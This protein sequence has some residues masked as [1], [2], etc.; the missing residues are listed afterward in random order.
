VWDLGDE[1]STWRLTLVD[2]EIRHGYGGAMNGLRIFWQLVA[3]ESWAGHWQGSRVSLA[4]RSG[5]GIVYAVSGLGYGTLKPFL[6][7]VEARPVL[8]RIRQE[9]REVC[10]S[11]WA[12]H[13]NHYIRLHDSLV[14][15]LSNHDYAAAC[16]ARAPCPWSTAGTGIRGF[17][18]P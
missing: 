13:C 7:E 18:P 14:T 12:D 16:C 5:I 4:I 6:T 10:A 11:R 8:D 15:A 17:L 9:L 1:G 3:F 2:I